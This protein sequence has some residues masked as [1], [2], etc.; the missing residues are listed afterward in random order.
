MARSSPTTLA[1]LF[2]RAPYQAY[3]AVQPPSMTS[4]A[5]VISA[6]AGEARKITA[7]MMS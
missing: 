4:A 3:Q 7:P 6:A 5:P 1:R 2:G